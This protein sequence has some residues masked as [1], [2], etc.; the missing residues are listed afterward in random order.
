MSPLPLSGLISGTNTEEMIRKIMSVERDRLTTKQVQQ[1][2]LATKQKAWGDVRSALS[3]LQSKLD[4]LRQPFIYRSRQVTMTNES[5]ATMT[6]DAGASLTTHTL[7]IAALAQSHV[8]SHS[9]AKAQASANDQLGVAGKFKIGTG[10]DL[11]E[12]ELKEDDTLN[13]LADKIND[14]KVGLSAAVVKVQINGEDKYRLV[15]SAAKSG[16]VNSVVMEEV[17]AEGT[18]L[19]D[20]GFK[21]ENGWLKQLSA[22]KDA[23]FTLDGIEYTRATNMVDDAVP[24]LTITLKKQGNDA[25]TQAAVSLN[26]GKVLESVKGWLDA[27]NSAQALL[28]KLG[29]YNAETKQAGVL[30]GDSLVRSLQGAIRKSISNVVAGLPADMNQMYHVGITTGAFGTSDYGKVIIDEAKFKKALEKD[31]DAVARLFGAQRNN[32]ALASNQAGITLLDGVP[33]TA[34][35]DVINGVT[36]NDRFGFP[37][38]GWQSDAAPTVEAPQ[39]FIINLNGKKTIDQISLFQFSS[40]DMPAQTHGLRNFKI[41]YWDDASASWKNLKEVENFKGGSSA[42]YD[43]NAVTTT[44]V[45]F[46]VTATY[47]NNPLRIREFSVN[48]MNN[49]AAIDMFRYIRS[50]LESDTG[51]MDT[52]DTT[53]KKQVERVR[54]DIDRIEQ[55]LAD[56]EDRLRKQFARMEAAMAKLRSQGLAFGSQLSGMM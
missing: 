14:A 54:D 28:K 48:E 8:L 11:K 49:G 56:R 5:V 23:K 30:N 44:K 55:Q 31:S 29:E 51:A 33:S 43:F 12:I 36:D 21:D 15:L 45:R 38:G 3:S 53:L 16:L 41:Q 50:T 27:V 17:D 9:D 10:T 6:A 2:Q 20:L 1:N 26:S 7:S 22:A 35:N 32:V 40:D 46:E 25:T 42:T 37:G 19:Q 47:G 18:V 52:R 34:L 24:G 13:S 39:G 4:S